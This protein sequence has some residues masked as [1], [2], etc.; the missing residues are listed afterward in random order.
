M[1]NI[2][3]T[4]FV[5]FID[6]AFTSSGDVIAAHRYSHGVRVYSFETGALLRSWGCEGN[7]DGQLRKPRA[8]AVANGLLY[9]LDFVPR[10]QD[11]IFS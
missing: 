1:R 5:G 4:G 9:V 2:G 10:R 3:V 6:L 8:I 7:D 11:A